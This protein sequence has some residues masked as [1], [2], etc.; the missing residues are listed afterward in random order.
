[1]ANIIIKSEDRINHE[2]TVLRSF[3]VFNGGTAEQKSA[4]EVIA[5]RTREV[6]GGE[7]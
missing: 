3:G 6:C 5:A 1:M 2:K 4:A 7:K